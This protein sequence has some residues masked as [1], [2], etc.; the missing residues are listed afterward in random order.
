LRKEVKT[1][2]DNFKDTGIYEIE[3]DAGNLTNGLLF[4]RIALENY[5]EIKKMMLMK[6]D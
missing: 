2:S 5:S 1:L 3:F 6:L 4:Y